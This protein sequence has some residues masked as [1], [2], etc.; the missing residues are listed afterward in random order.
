MEFLFLFSNKTTSKKIV[1]C[2]TI[3]TRSKSYFY[4]IVCNNKT[5]MNKT[6]TI[7]FQTLGNYFLR[8]KKGLYAVFGEPKFILDRNGILIYMH[9]SNLNDCCQCMSY[10]SSSKHQGVKYV[11][12]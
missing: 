10:I 2:K 7:I 6:V 8:F 11:R 3:T 4:L 1:I 12:K 5:T 9:Y